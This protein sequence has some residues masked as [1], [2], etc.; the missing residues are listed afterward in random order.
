MKKKFKKI[1]KIKKI[2]KG[3]VSKLQHVCIVKVSDITNWRQQ[4]VLAL[5]EA[6]KNQTQNVKYSEIQRFISLIAEY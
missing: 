5:K 1:K 4:M 3:I 6:L 2:K